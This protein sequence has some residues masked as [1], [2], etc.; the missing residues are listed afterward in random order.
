[1]TSADVPDARGSV[2]LAF[3]TASPIKGVKVFLQV[4]V[5]GNA[6][7]SVWI[8]A[9][10]ALFA[11]GWFVTEAAGI[12]VAKQFTI[13]GASGSVIFGLFSG[14]LLMAGKRILDREAA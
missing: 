14:L 8:V 6:C 12:D 9:M 5:Y 2:S 7:L 10:P 13:L 1:V 4:D 11:L 3:R